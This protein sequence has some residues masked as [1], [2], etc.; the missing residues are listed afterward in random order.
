MGFTV[1]GEN[2]FLGSGHPDPSEQRPPLLGLIESRDG[3]KTWRSISML[4]EAD[5]HVL[6]AQGRTVYGYDAS[7]GRFL[8]SNDGGAQ[9]SERTAPEAL[10]ALAVD[11]RDDQHL[12][13]SGRAELYSSSTGGRTPL[14][15]KLSLANSTSPCTMARFGGPSMAEGHGA[16]VRAV[17]DFQF[18]AIPQ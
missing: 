18:S 9:W 5:F 17:T 13:A 2:H 7:G 10:L 14:R 3:G 15:L 12:V 11:P 1:V 4:G 16:Q 6:E 8:A